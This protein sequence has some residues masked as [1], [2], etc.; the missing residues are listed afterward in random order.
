MQHHFFAT[1][2]RRLLNE[3]SSKNIWK[4]VRGILN[5]GGF[6]VKMVG[7]L[8]GKKEAAY[9]WTTINSLLQTKQVEFYAYKKKLSREKL[10]S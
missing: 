4:T 7:T 8:P 5:N 3:S 2:F 10:K 9:S 6:L 1:F